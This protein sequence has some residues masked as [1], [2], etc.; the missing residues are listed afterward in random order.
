[1]SNTAV[2]VAESLVIGALAGFGASAGAARMFHAPTVQG[3]TLASL[4][5]AKGLEWDAVFLVGLSEGLMP[6]S[7]AKGD[8]VAE[9]RRLLYVGVTRAKEDLF[10]SY[11]KGNAGRGNRKM[12]RF[13]EGLWPG[14]EP[15]RATTSRRRSKQDRDEFARAH[16]E[17]QDLFEELRAWRAARSAELE[18]PAYT[19][20][21]DTTLRAIALSKPRNLSELGGVKGVGTTKLTTYGPE[22]LAIVNSRR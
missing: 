3:I 6:I 15:S 11:A 13:L 22:I 14:A 18:R 1:M 7:L 16:P 5:S 10:I 4:H 17:D 19:I 20:L 8:D 12:S 2:I 21:H 9:E